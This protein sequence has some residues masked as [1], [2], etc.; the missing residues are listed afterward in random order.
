MA[1]IFDALCYFLGN[2]NTF[3]IS[4]IDNANRDFGLT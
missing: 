1:R 3:I 4:K 2:A